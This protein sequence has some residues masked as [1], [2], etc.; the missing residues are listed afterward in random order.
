MA[1]A[2]VVYSLSPRADPC[3]MLAFMELNADRKRLAT[4]N[5]S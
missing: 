2:F 3:A 4:L 5:F 1:A